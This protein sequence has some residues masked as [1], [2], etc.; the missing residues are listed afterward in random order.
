[1]RAEGGGTCIHHV[2]LPS[3]SPSSTPSCLLVYVTLPLVARCHISGSSVPPAQ[4][5]AATIHQ[6]WLNTSAPL[7][8]LSPQS[9]DHHCL[10]LPLPLTQTFNGSPVLFEQRV[11]LSWLC[12]LCALVQKPVS[13]VFPALFSRLSL[14]TQGCSPSII[15]IA[16]SLVSTKIMGF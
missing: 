16:G 14:R 13:A 2:G 1:M 15:S 7:S 8:G 10:P 5:D 12:G 9:S 3:L 6:C 11:I 4:W